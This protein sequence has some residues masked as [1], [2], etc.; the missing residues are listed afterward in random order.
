VQ[1]FSVGPASDSHAGGTPGENQLYHRFHRVQGGFLCVE[2][3]PAEKTSE[4]I[5]QLRDAEGKVSYESKF[6]RAA[7]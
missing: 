3:R 2:L 6:A 7:V 1:E 5:F 4:M